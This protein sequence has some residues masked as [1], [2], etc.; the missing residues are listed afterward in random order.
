MSG[1]TQRTNGHAR[2]YD[3]TKVIFVLFG[4]V[5]SLG[6]IL[7]TQAMNRLATIEKKQE[8]NTERTVTTERD[9]KNM[10]EDIQE[11]RQDVKELLNRRNQ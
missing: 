1:E 8:R 9:V 7:H 3:S 2:W 11:I 5:L 6:G 10:H 4:L